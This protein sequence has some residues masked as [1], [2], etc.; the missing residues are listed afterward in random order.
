MQVGWVPV[1]PSE[2]FHICC[3]DVVIDRTVITAHGPV[4]LNLRWHSEILRNFV[5]S[6]TV[7]GQSQ[8]LIIDVTIAVSGHFKH[9]DDIV[10]A[11]HRPMMHAVHDLGFVTP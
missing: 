5:K 8:G 2:I 7:I 9:C 11:P 10:V 6:L 1:K 3:L 4:L